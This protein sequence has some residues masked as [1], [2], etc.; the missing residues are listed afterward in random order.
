MSE[1][2]PPI[3]QAEQLTRRERV[4]KFMRELDSALGLRSPA[5]GNTPDA[6]YNNA[7]AIHELETYANTPTDTPD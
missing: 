1:M 4:I 5:F 2:K 3:P 7:Q 6:R